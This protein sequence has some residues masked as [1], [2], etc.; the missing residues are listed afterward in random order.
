MQSVAPTKSRVW[1]KEPY[2]WMLI[3]F[4]LSSI[5]VCSFL[6]TVAINTKDSLVRG[7]YY[8]DGMA[9]NEELK[10]DNKA[11]AMDIR[12]AYTIK[13]NV[14]SLTVLNSRLDMPSTLLIK[15]SHPTLQGKDRDSLLQLK[16]GSRSY[17]GFID[18]VQDGK[19]YIQVECAEQSWRI[20]GE[21]YL[22]NGESHS[23]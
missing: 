7:N 6:L 15:F 16:P 21:V 18:S 1:Y 13:D 3:A 20:R 14:A 17:Q 8:K 4:P 10:W 23:L 9:M 12:V 22:I 11:R 19:Y 2:V 5:I